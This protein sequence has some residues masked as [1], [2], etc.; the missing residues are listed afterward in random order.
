MKHYTVYTCKCYSSSGYV[1]K[2][3]ISKPCNVCGE[4]YI[5][6]YF[7]HNLISRRYYNMKRKFIYLIVIVSTV[8]IALGCDFDCKP[9]LFKKVPGFR[10]DGEF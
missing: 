4:S 6:L 1:E 3:Q 8:F 9:N 10:C 5:G 7:R 2:G